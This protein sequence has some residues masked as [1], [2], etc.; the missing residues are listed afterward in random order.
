M[1]KKK[2]LPLLLAAVL[3]LSFLPVSARADGSSTPH[4]PRQGAGL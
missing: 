1:N 3:L 4:L 2:L